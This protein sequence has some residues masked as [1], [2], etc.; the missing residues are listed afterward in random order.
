MFFI[1]ED[2]KIKV[3][4]ISQF[5]FEDWE[6]MLKGMTNLRGAGEDAVVVEMIGYI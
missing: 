6:N 5:Q 3:V 4:D 1:N 2:D